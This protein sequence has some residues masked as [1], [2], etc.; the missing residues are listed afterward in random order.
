[1]KS[2]DNLI[3]FTSQAMDDGFDEIIQ[4]DWE[5]N[6]SIPNHTH[7]YDVRVQVAAGQVTLKLGETAQTYAAGQ[8]FYLARD[9]EHAEQYG[10]QG[11]SFWVARKL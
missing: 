5:P 6:L 10:P 3:E 11:A 4:K 8:G 9:V 7:P 1:M 2:H